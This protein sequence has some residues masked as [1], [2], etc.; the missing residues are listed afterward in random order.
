MREAGKSPRQKAVAEW[1]QRRLSVIIDFFIRP[2]TMVWSINAS[3]RLRR[4][5]CLSRLSQPT[6]LT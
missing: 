3:H 6:A 2:L 4:N 1:S 5:G